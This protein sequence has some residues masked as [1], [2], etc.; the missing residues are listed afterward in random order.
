MKYLY[1]YRTSDNVVHNGEVFAPNR[2][3]AFASLKKD[4]IKPFSVTEA[5]GFFNRFFGKGKRWTAIAVLGII[6]LASTFKIVRDRSKNELPLLSERHQIYGDPAI[7][8]ELERNNY[9]SVFENE[10]ERYLASFARPGLPRS[11]PR[12]TPET[13]KQCLDH[14]ITISETD[15]REVREL[16]AIVNGLKEE[17]KNYLTDGDIRSYMELLDQR[18]KDERAIYLRVERELSDENN[19]TV[20]ESKNTEL[21]AMGLR[22]VPKPRKW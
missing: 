21:H 14:P 4:G 20:R 11:G 9:A 15:S 8:D 19:D 17:M 1:Q 12:P 10:G 5:P 3:A 2:D 16:K 22:T 13:L 7:M 18:Q 6:A